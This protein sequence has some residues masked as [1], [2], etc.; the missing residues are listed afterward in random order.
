MRVHGDEGGQGPGRTWPITGST[1]SS[2]GPKGISGQ[3]QSPAEVDATC[4]AVQGEL[5]GG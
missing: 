1:G 2:V 3:T 4:L 5:V